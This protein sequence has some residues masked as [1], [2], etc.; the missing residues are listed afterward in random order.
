MIENDRKT[1]TPREPNPKGS[2]ERLGR[3]PLRLGKSAITEDIYAGYLSKDGKTWVKKENVTDEFISA[4]IARWGGF[5]ETLTAS[6]GTRYEVSVRIE[7]PNA[8]SEVQP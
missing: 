8:E 1:E 3:S 2:H 4:V 7:R 6:D 5:R